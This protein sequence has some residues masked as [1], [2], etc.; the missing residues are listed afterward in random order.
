MRLKLCKDCV[1]F[2]TRNYPEVQTR[3]FCGSENGNDYITGAKRI[4]SCYEMRQTDNLC[5]LNARWFKS[6]RK[7]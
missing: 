6:K 1:H 7:R 3:H 2:Q 4:R 5:S